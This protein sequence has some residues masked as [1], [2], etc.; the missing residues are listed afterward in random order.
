M[1]VALSNSLRKDCPQEDIHTVAPTS[2]VNRMSICYFTVSRIISTILI[3][4][5]SVFCSGGLRID[6]IWGGGLTS[7]AGAQT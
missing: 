1:P 7:N 6:Q 5:F 4:F 3:K 2:R